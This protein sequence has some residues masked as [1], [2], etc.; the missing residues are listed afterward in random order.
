MTISIKQFEILFKTCC[1]KAKNQKHARVI[2]MDKKLFEVHLCFEMYGRAIIL[3]FDL[4]LLT[5]VELLIIF[6]FLFVFDFI[7]IKLLLLIC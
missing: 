7:V 2:K 5:S 4:W 1:T 6:A 3:I